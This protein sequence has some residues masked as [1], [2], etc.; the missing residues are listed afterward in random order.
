[1]VLTLPGTVFANVAC[2]VIVC[3]ALIIIHCQNILRINIGVVRDEEFASHSHTNLAFPRA[4]TVMRDDL[5]LA[6]RIDVSVITSR[7]TP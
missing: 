5:L 3:R 2:Q 1:V 4:Q 6:I 7:C